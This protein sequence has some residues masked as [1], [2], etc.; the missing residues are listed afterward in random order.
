MPCSA[1]CQ[2]GMLQGIAPAGPC[3]G[4]HPLWCRNVLRYGWLC[5]VEGQCLPH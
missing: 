4:L 1:L 3:A 5:I 2:R